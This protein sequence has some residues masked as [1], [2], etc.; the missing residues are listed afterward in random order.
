MTK[1]T[2]NV[3]TKWVVEFYGF[4]N[5]VP[6]SGGEGAQDFFKSSVSIIGS[7]T[8]V[9][10]QATS[11]I[12]GILGKNSNEIEKS[13]GLRSIS[14]T[15]SKGD[16][17]GQCNLV[18]AGPLPTNVYV[19]VWVVVSSVTKSNGTAIALPRFIGQI[20]TVE[21]NYNFVQDGLL[22]SMSSI[23]IKEWSSILNSEIRFDQISLEASSIINTP[24]GAQSFLEKISAANSGDGI[25]AAQDL[26]KNAWDPLG[27]AQATLKL[28]GSLNR[29]DELVD[30][31]K[32][33]TA[34]PRMAI[35]APSVP[36][37]LI[38]RIGMGSLININP[39][40]MYKSGFLKVVSGSHVHNDSG[41]Y[42]QWDGFFEPGGIDA[43]SKKT[44][45]AYESTPYKPK[46]IGPALILSSG[47]SAWQI[48]SEYCDPSIYEYYTDLW[49]ERNL[50]G[51]IKTQPVL[52]MR[53]KPFL[54]AN[55]QNKLLD[56]IISKDLS[57]FSCYD[58]IPRISIPEVS[59]AGMAVQNTTIN[60]PNYFIINFTGS[61]NYLNMDV[62][63][64]IPALN[65]RKKL[66]AEMDRYGGKQFALQTNFLGGDWQKKSG[67]TL[68]VPGISGDQIP[69]I[70]WYT[71]LKELACGWHGFDYRM[72]SGSL[73]I[74]DKNYPISV[75]NNIQWNFN[76]R[77]LVGHVES[78][79]MNF[80]I[81]PDGLESTNFDLRVSR[82]VESTSNP[83]DLLN[84][85]S[86]AL[87]LLGGNRTPNL[88][89]V[90]MQDWGRM[91]R[92]RK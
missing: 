36:V 69:I 84:K 52:V 87:S 13:F 67:D 1:S 22:V 33:E 34:L 30:L 23:R 16:P 15:R 71:M 11:A 37:E 55:V 68:S 19:G 83:N 7:A 20:T 43:Y 58:Y 4:D 70:T 6:S 18:Y 85:A 79:S 77:S 21:T 25:S 54:M 28:I 73:K 61:N 41:V 53:D 24:P 31:P 44:K 49:Y 26:L 27:L 65:G 46:S 88:D 90:P 81:N 9:V 51:S 48:L 82:I 3:S 75:G 59:I 78:I 8:S 57:A 32:T 50:D 80:Q 76:G 12:A 10:S 39:R 86:S 29:I 74:K 45:E 92:P 56:P 17:A 62:A 89:F 72:G 91:A 5:P 42:D 60:S 66:Q 40:D 2:L 63:G 14:I 47:K 38:R 64:T 35:T